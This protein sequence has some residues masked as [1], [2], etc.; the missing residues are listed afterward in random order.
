MSDENQVPGT[1]PWLKIPSWALPFMYVMGGG[2]LG[3]GGLSLTID[4]DEEE[5]VAAPEELPPEPSIDDGVEAGTETIE[6][7]NPV[8]C[9]EQEAPEPIACDSSIADSLRDQLLDTRTQLSKCK[10]RRRA[11]DD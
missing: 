8:E 11:D 3:F 4:R 7:V 10:A 2:T 9:P 5:V 1:N 6:T